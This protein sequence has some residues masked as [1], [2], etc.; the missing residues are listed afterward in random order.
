MI[1]G[2][3]AQQYAKK[4]PPSIHIKKSLAEVMDYFQISRTID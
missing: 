2:L 1:S 3:L 4:V